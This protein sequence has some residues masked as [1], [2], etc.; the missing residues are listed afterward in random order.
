MTDSESTSRAFYKKLGPTGLAAM[1][2][3]GRGE[4]DLELLK[5]FS[6]KSDQILDLACGYG[7]VTIPAAA[8]GYQIVGL[9]LSRKLITHARKEA[10]K[11]EV[12][13]KFREGSMLDLPFKE[14]SFDKVFCFWSSFNYLLKR[15]EQ[16][17]AVNEMHRI[18]KPGGMVLLEM[19]NGEKKK[20][21]QKVAEVGTGEDGRVW[22]ESFNGTFNLCYVHTRETLKAVC[23]ASQVT[24]Y[25]VEF[26]ELHKQTRIVM[27]LY[28]P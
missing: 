26:M 22:G 14:A 5:Q 23:E 15:S 16:I 25:E 9:D 6:T 11:R 12:E 21:A 24:K 20:L 8:A 27:K 19:M 2:A 28:R 18:V 1:A 17:Q 4:D 7:R 10:K 3:S 13:V